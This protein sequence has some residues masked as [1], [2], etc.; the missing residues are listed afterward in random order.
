MN[1]FKKPYHFIR[2]NYFGNGGYSPYSTDSYL[3]QAPRETSVFYNDRVAN[4][5]L[6]N[7]FQ[8]LQDL[9]L[10]P[11][12]AVK[13]DFKTENKKLKYIVEQSKV[14]Y[15]SIETL[16]DFKL[17]G[18]CFFSVTTDIKKNEDDKNEVDNEIIPEIDNVFVGDFVELKMNG[19][20]VKTAVYSE[21][22]MLD[23]VKVPILVKFENGIFTKKTQAWRLDKKT[24][25]LDDLGETKRITN[26]DG[27]RYGTLNKIGLRLDDIPKTFN[28]A[29][30]QKQ[31][32]NLDTQ[33]LDILRK[34]G[35]PI[36]I[37]QSDD[38]LKE[39][40]L[41]MDTIIQVPAEENVKHMPEYIEA[42][43]EGVSLTTEIIEEK[44]STVYKVFTNGLFSDNIKYTST[45]STVIATKTFTNVVNTLYLVWQDILKTML[46]DIISIYDLN[47]KYTIKYPSIDLDSE[48][49]KTQA[50]EI[51]D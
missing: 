50:V 33:R 23:N 28:L 24:V 16:T 41:S 39:I 21:Y 15:N 4:S 8:P 1:E 5:T 13:P 14:F 42:Q 40:S 48:D 25:T 12:K 49:I 22:K 36:L 30:I 27:V 18:K 38:D 45:M 47:T 20:E 2:D 7:L 35:F 43:L 11:I 29:Q 34:A 37:I 10:D 17:Y 44:K 9:F 6:E 32:F 26:F 51:L 19:L 31:L 3:I 46:D